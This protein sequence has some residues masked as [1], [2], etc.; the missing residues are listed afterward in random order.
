VDSLVD[1]RPEPPTSC[2]GGRVVT[3]PPPCWTVPGGPSG[4]RW[5]LRLHVYTDIAACTTC[6]FHTITPPTG[7]RS[8]LWFA[9]CFALPACVPFWTG[10][11]G[12]STT[13]ADE[14]RRGL[15]AGSHPAPTRFLPPHRTGSGCAT[16]LPFC[17]SYSCHPAAGAFHR[18]PAPDTPLDDYAMVAAIYGHSL[19]SV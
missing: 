12:R 10:L 16:T 17:R 3:T 6:L 18:L 11:R 5:G 1:Y 13:D 9:A 7:G 19:I 8:A 15:Q 4:W 2:T 14:P